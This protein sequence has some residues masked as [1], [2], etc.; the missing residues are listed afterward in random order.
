MAT[1]G[2]GTEQRP[3]FRSVLSFFLHARRR[4][5]AQPVTRDTG[6]DMSDESVDVVR[7]AFEAWRGG[8]DSL[9]EFLSEEIDWEVRPDLPD[10]GRYRGHDGFRR[11][12][13]RFDDVMVDMWFRPVELIAVGEDQVVVP[14]TWG[15]RGKGS[16]LAF[17][18]RAETWVFT[19]AGGKITRVKEFAT[20]EQAL[21]AVSE[22]DSRRDEL[23]R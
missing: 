1:K 21:T 14:L 11:L 18:E 19:V 16:G 9:L 20:R 3:S 17:E 13:A 8:G 4:F 10:A 6:G 23:R 22:E 2:E 5:H 7:A 12:S 15:G